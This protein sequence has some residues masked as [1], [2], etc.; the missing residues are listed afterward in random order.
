MILYGYPIVEE[1]KS[2]LIKEF[3][4]DKWKDKYITIFLLQNHK[5]SIVYVNK[6]KDF[7]EEIWI[8]VNVVDW[9]K[10]TGLS[11][12]L[13]YI[14][15]FNKDKNCVWI[16]VQLPLPDNLRKYQSYILSKIS[17]LKDIDW[18]GWVLFWLSQ[19]WL[20]DFVPATPKAAIKLLDYY[21]LSDFRWKKVSILGQSNLVW[22]PLALEIIKRWWEVF[23]FNHFLNENEIIKFIRQSDIIFSATWKNY[24]VDSNWINKDHIIVDIWWWLV[25]WK[26]AGDVNFEEVKNKVKAITPVPGWVWPITVASL[27]ENIIV[28]NKFKDIINSVLSYR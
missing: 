28:L 7:W 3:K 9:F 22:K 14:D 8:N 19:I 11:D 5:P 10:I 15:F 1:I 16:V 26:P 24:L 25:N 4:K 23:S 21:N 6:K 13:N 17:P 12:L 18:L 27:F 20:I 2:N